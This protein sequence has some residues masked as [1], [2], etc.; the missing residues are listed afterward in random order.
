M[1]KVCQIFIIIF[2]KR[3]HPAHLLHNL[4]VLLVF[5]LQ[6]VVHLIPKPRCRAQPNWTVDT[7]LSLS[8]P[9][10]PP[11][12]PSPRPPCLPSTS[13]RPLPSKPLCQAQP[14]TL[15]S[16]SLPSC[17][18][19]SPHLLILRVFLLHHVHFLHNLTHYYHDRYHPAH[20]VHPISSSSVFSF[21]ITLPTS[22]KTSLSYI[23]LPQRCTHHIVG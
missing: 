12:S 6:H 16:R 19:V 3:H 2:H 22:S 4:L 18:P 15:L 8:L 11:A 5:L 10:Y 9:S 7:L 21:Y 23:E 14:N 20:L 1:L 13:R 17:P